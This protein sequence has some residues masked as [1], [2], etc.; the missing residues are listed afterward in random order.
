M[1]PNQGFLQQGF[2][3]V[4]IACDEELGVNVLEQLFYI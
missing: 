3:M 2:Q 4:E 1:L